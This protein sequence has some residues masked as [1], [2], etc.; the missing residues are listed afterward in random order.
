MIHPLM[1]SKY[2]W[3]NFKY[4][5][6]LRRIES[7]SPF[8]S[9]DTYRLA[10][11]FDTS[12]SERFSDI[13]TEHTSIFTTP[14]V[15]PEFANYVESR[16]LVLQNS[17]L[18]IHNGDK[19]PNSS[20][21]EFL[22]GRFNRIFSVNW[23][24]VHPNIEPIPIGLENISYLRNGIPGDYR[25]NISKNKLEF[26]ER[27][28]ELLVAF[29]LHTNPSERT[30]AMLEAKKIPGAKIIE[31]FIY[32]YDYLRLVAQ[33]KFVLSPPGN[34]PD[35]HRTWESIYLGAVPIVLRSAW[36]FRD[37]ELPVVMVDNWTEISKVI[38]SEN[39]FNFLSVEQI[40]DMFISRFN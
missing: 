29:S 35:C 1:H 12:S 7:S 31:E 3:R 5:V 32:P 8:L 13:S 23:L 14:D 24:G 34:G 28:I 6:G 18:V 21:L 9:G 15:L 10:C 20:T 11:D 25:K 26:I 4:K 27:P 33:S 40:H 37:F 22:S 39:V 19:V 2:K 38:N 16:D 30:A 17:N 36:P